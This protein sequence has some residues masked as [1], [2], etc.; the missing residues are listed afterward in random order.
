MRLCALTVW[1]RRQ[2]RRRRWP[3]QFGL[4]PRLVHN[5][6]LPSLYSRG[7]QL[8]SFADHVTT[9]WVSRGPH[10]KQKKPHFKLSNSL[11]AGRYVTRG[12][13][14]AP[15]CSTALLFTAEEKNGYDFYNLRTFLLL[16]IRFRVYINIVNESLRFFLLI[17]NLS[18]EMFV[19][20]VDYYC[21]LLQL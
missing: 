19:F 11:T 4:L 15:S 7:G 12:P 1:R 5:L 17:W 20:V 13:Y 9:L 21:R 14:V 16:L 10:F 6:L 18:A 2:R 8:F 3:G